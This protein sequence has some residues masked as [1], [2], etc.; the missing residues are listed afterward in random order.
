MEDDEGKGSFFLLAGIEGR[1]PGHVEISHPLCS[2]LLVFFHSLGTISLQTRS[3]IPEIN[4]FWHDEEPT[5]CW[6]LPTEYY[7]T[8][9]IINQGESST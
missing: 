7:H 5:V 6:N 9:N 1:L 4:S 8:I 2:Q 3:S